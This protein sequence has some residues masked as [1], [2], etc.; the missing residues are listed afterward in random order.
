MKYTDLFAEKRFNKDEQ[1]LKDNLVYECIVGSQA[2]GLATPESDVD[3]VGLVMPKEEHLFPQRYGYIL[4]YGQYPK[5][6]SKEVKGPGKRIELTDSKHSDVEGE[7]VSLVRFFELCAY[8]G[9]PNLIETLFVRRPL[10][11]FGTDIAWK[12]RDN[13]LKFLSMRTFSAFKGYCFAQIA[14]I[15][16]GAEKGVAE[17]PKRQEYL[18]KFGY[19]VKMS[20]HPLR[21]LDQLNQ[22]LDEGTIDLMRNKEEC[23]AMRK[24]EWG[25][26]KTFDR[27][28]NERLQALE[29]K[30]LVS[31]AIAPKPRLGELKVLLAECIEEWYGTEGA[32]Q[33]Q[34]DYVSVQELWNRLDKMEAKWK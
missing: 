28:M 1:W 27:V 31:N 6:D 11:T 20:Y 25:D 3:I 29:K 9:S 12:L 10:V 2:Y 21:L 23:K 14:R 17:T 22:L 18:D 13:K 15:R 7:W 33:K 16:R 26:F 5:F 30:A 24:G 34:T 32:M 8:K 4:G 19:D